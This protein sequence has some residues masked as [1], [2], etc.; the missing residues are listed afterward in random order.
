MK[1]IFAVIAAIF[2]SISAWAGIGLPIHMDNLVM[3]RTLGTSSSPLVDARVKPLMDPAF[4]S[5]I[6]FYS[7]FMMWFESGG[8]GYMGLQKDGYEGKKAIFSMWDT[9]ANM[10]QAE[11]PHCKRFGHEGTGAMCLIKYDWEV[12]HEYKFFA[13]LHQ[14]AQ[15]NRMAMSAYIVDIT[16]KKETHIGT[17]NIPDV[18]GYR[19]Y[20]NIAAM[21]YVHEYY[22]SRTLD[23]C[24]QLPQ[25][26][27]EWTMPAF[28]HGARF[29][30]VT[31]NSETGVGY[32]CPNKNITQTGPWSY[33]SIAGG[34]TKNT[35]ANGHQFA[36]E[37]TVDVFRK[38]DCYY[39][40][41]EAQFNDLL[42]NRDTVFNKVS[43][44]DQGTNQYYR[45]Y[46]GTNAQGQKD[47]FK[48]FVDTVQQDVYVVKYP[49]EKYLYGGKWQNNV[50]NYGCN[51][52]KK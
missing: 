11:T 31:Y 12:G 35:V 28:E 47:G 51:V 20:G 6:G 8:G 18:S 29:P 45:D 1:K 48:V 41:V 16:A 33:V 2:M 23:N 3:T 10:V 49:E 46:S 21:V 39:D 7:Q 22:G 4:P 37:Q 38:I 36:N 25:M 24:G 17:I 26:A 14:S 52:Y 50:N 5:D 30:T 44:F 42:H 15:T 9:G 19:G 43:Q 40:K 27:V 13:H 34:D 32:N